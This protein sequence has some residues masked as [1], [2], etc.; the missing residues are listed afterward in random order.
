MRIGRNQ[1]VKNGV[2]GMSQNLRIC[3]QKRKRKN[4]SGG[5]RKSYERET[6]CN[7]VRFK[8]GSKDAKRRKQNP[9][10]DRKSDGQRKMHNI[11]CKETPDKKICKARRRWKC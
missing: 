5:F 7:L 2:D 1:T 4:K 3:G 8:K 9:S 6:G 10:A 11:D